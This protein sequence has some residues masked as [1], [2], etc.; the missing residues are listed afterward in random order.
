[1]SRHYYDLAQMAGS[2]VGESALNR[3][4]LLERV[5]TFKTVYFPTAWARYDL[6]RP[7]T[8]RLVPEQRIMAELQRDYAAM[9]PMF[10]GDAPEFESIVDVLR[11]LESRING[12][13]E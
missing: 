7:G 13:V 8:L 11:E 12:V 4:D 10:F 6:A 9:Q 2:P 1:M 5:A 3:I